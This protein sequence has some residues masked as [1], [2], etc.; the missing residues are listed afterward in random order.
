[1]QVVGIILGK[2]I[3]LR[4]ER[5]REE[6]LELTLWK[7][8]MELRGDDEVLGIRSLSEISSCSGIGSEVDRGKLDGFILF[9]VL[10]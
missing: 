3:I 9:L 6:N 4:R 8:C 10:L 5:R 2:A 1:M 7:R